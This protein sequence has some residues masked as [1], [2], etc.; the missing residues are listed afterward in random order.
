M[1]GGAIV[2]GLVKGSV[3]L[4]KA[5]SAAVDDFLVHVDSAKL[6]VDGIENF[7]N[8]KGLAKA[9]LEKILDESML[10][11]MRSTIA[12]RGYV[13]DLFASQTSR[14]DFAAQLDTLHRD[15]IEKVRHTDSDPAELLADLRKDWADEVALRDAGIERIMA[16]RGLTEAQALPHFAQDMQRHM[17]SM[18][19]A[20]RNAANSTG[21][22]SGMPKPA[23]N[24][25]G[26]WRPRDGRRRRPTA[27][28]REDGDGLTQQQQQQ[29]WQSS[30][31]FDGSEP[32]PVHRGEGEPEWRRQGSG[33]RSVLQPDQKPRIDPDA[34]DAKVVDE[35][36]PPREDPEPTGDPDATNSSATERLSG[37]TEPPWP[38]NSR[39]TRQSS[40]SVNPD[41]IPASGT[42]N[43]AMRSARWAWN[44]TLGYTFNFPLRLLRDATLLLGNA[45][46][47]ARMG[48]SFKFND[49]IRSHEVFA[50]GD[51][52]KPTNAAGFAIAVDPKMAVRGQNKVYSP[53]GLTRHDLAGAVSKLRTAFEGGEAQTLIDTAA[54]LKRN[55]GDLNERL[56]HI[57]SLPPMKSGDELTGGTIVARLMAHDLRPH[58]EVLNELSG[59]LDNISSGSP[60][61][62]LSA[63][64]FEQ[65]QQAV[66]KINEV[67]SQYTRVTQAKNTDL[68]GRP[69]HVN[70]DDRANTAFALE[71]GEAGRI[72]REITSADR[73][74]FRNLARRGEIEF[75]LRDGQSPNDVTVNNLIDYTPGEHAF[76]SASR[77]GN[78]NHIFRTE[79]QRN[80]EYALVS[81]GKD[82]IERAAQIAAE[83]MKRPDGE[84][85][86][87][88][89]L[90]WAALSYARNLDESGNVIRK[91]TESLERREKNFI[92]DFA[93]ELRRRDAGMRESGQQTEIFSDEFVQNIA[94][95]GSRLF[96]LGPNDIRGAWR[97]MWDR[98]RYLRF[99]GDRSNEMS[100]D[101]DRAHVSRWENDYGPT[102][103]QGMA[104]SSRL[105]LAL[106]PLAGAERWY[107]R[108]IPI[109]FENSVFWSGMARNLPFRQTYFGD[110][111][112]RRQ[113]AWNLGRWTAINGVAGYTIYDYLSD[114]NKTQQPTQNQQQS[115]AP[116]TSSGN[117]G[118][119]WFNPVGWVGGSSAPTLTLADAKTAST[120]N[121]Q[122]IHDLLNAQSATGLHTLSNGL[123]NYLDSNGRLLQHTTTETTRIINEQN[124]ILA[125]PARTSEHP[126]AATKK[127]NFEIVRGQVLQL[128]NNF[129]ARASSDEALIRRFLDDGDPNTSDDILAQMQKLN[130]D[131][132]SAPD[133][134]AANALIEQQRALTAQVEEWKDLFTQRHEQAIQSF[135]NSNLLGLQNTFSQGISKGVP[136]FP[137]GANGNF[138]PSLAPTIPDIDVKKPDGT[139]IQAQ[140]IFA[141]NGNGGGGRPTDFANLTTPNASL[142][143]ASAQAEYT[144]IADAKAASEKILNEADRLRFLTAAD[145]ERRAQLFETAFLRDMTTELD[146]KIAAENTDADR[147]P[148]EALKAQLPKFVAQHAAQIRA[149]GGT[150][151]GTLDKAGA[152][153]VQNIHAQDQ[154][155]RSMTDLAQ[156]NTALQQQTTFLL[157]MQALYN[158]GVAQSKESARANID[159]FS[160]A[161]ENA[162]PF[163]TVPVPAA[164]TVDT[165]APTPAVTNTGTN[166]ATNSTGAPAG[167]T[168]GT[169]AQVTL[170]QAAAGG[171]ATVTSLA[172]I[173]ARA[174]IT[175]NENLETFNAKALT[176]SNRLIEMEKELY[177]TYAKDAV[178]RI[179]EK[180]ALTTTDAAADQRLQNLKNQLSDEAWQLNVGIFV[181][182]I[183]RFDQNATAFRADMVAHAAAI[184]TAPDADAVKALLEK[185]TALIAK[186]ENPEQLSVMQREFNTFKAKFDAKITAGTAMT[187][188]ELDS[189]PT[190]GS[191]SKAAWE[192][193]LADIKAD[194]AKTLDNTQKYGA[195][196]SGYINDPGTPQNSAKEYVAA[197]NATI[198]QAEQ[199]KTEI[200]GSDN[201]LS[202]KTQRINS[203]T[204]LIRGITKNRDEIQSLIPALERYERATKPLLEQA[205]KLRTQIAGLSAEADVRTAEGLMRHLNTISGKVKD[206]AN[207]AYEGSAKKIQALFNESEKQAANNPE[208]DFANNKINAGLLRAGGKNSLGFRTFGTSNPHERSWFKGAFDT[209]TAIPGEFLKWWE[210]SKRA[211]SATQADR[212]MMNLIEHGGLFLAGWMAL[213]V[214]NRNLF[215]GKMSSIM[216]IAAL[217][218]LVIMLNGRSGRVG[219]EMEAYAKG[220]NTWALAQGGGGNLPNKA[221]N[222]NNAPSGNN[223]NVNTVSTKIPVRDHNNV[224]DDHVFTA[225][226]NIY[227]QE[228]RGGMPLELAADVDRAVHQEG[229]DQAIWCAQNNFS[230]TGCHL[231][232]DTT[233]RGTSILGIYHHDNTNGA[234]AQEVTI[235]SEMSKQAAIA[236]MEAQAGNAA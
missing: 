141:P 144:N 82:N 164:L 213:G 193:T 28:V 111:A 231:I 87:Y 56:D 200:S 171:G 68:F 139:I 70:P 43:F 104:M 79:N 77:N 98:H 101:F 22:P 146:E 123:K 21:A 51:T 109:N 12:Y 131:I 3:E 117:S 132:Q 151:G 172:D 199:L 210:D 145:F 11:R 230:G 69:T 80:L 9:D 6:N 86:I 55:L 208:L 38:F 47:Y 58:M 84:M 207:Q 35:T 115:T 228:H 81:G 137:L 156:I 5:G 235:T 124:A 221:A 204:G 138:D 32:N 220:N 25:D 90:K 94:H 110:A 64:Q 234:P 216:K 93:D 167:A 227:A 126:A 45:R 61:S 166:T 223:K 122:M 1:A 95:F 180:I 183:E 29:Q 215:D 14:S 57:N 74:R 161:I 201:N 160:I 179:D 198:K 116:Q 53:K 100:S 153:L 157:Q 205:E 103:L 20:R 52:F 169:A 125:D 225:N 75:H 34:E 7:F 50:A 218:A 149:D 133:A 63:A 99:A 39:N 190:R 96:A 60:V 107:L 24:A 163:G 46:T 211:N 173:R 184:A 162:A 54:I 181:R 19:Q 83:M 127:K 65:A 202:Y 113:T 118:Y 143:L 175:A 42:G 2:R 4:S 186:V 71:T 152:T 76:N 224:R 212:D 232:D 176:S 78:F 194:A 226:G 66:A 154:K 72:E 27:R 209:A 134:D 178:Q 185:Q 128:A 18:E 136:L 214:A 62:S 206:N 91:G 177:Y 30:A 112:T 140:N 85:R 130:N 121:V 148:Y 108:P 97:D 89:A 174:A 114:P 192:H 195:A 13:A 135:M 92:R 119:S 49:H 36:P 217:G 142:V 120:A 147:A 188:T 10:R 236:L 8:S 196:I 67:T 73:R 229:N 155:V 187:D 168:T 158:D 17:Q 191:G 219:D 222:T 41:N 44:N 31:S 16:D 106:N 88:E 129:E 102:G 182:E 105:G 159:A 26:P 150:P 203:L 40:Q 33:H 170:A 165:P 59:K 23:A 37:R 233:F 189:I 15:Y 197:I 48:A